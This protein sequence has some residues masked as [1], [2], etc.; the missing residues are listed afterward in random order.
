MCLSWMLVPHRHTSPRT[1][2]RHGGGVAAGADRARRSCQQPPRR[3]T[4]GVGDGVWMT[5]TTPCSPC[6]NLSGRTHASRCPPS[7]TVT[8]WDRQT[9]T[10]AGREA[11]HDGL[12]PRKSGVSPAPFRRRSLPPRS[13]SAQLRPD[14]YRGRD[15]PGLQLSSCNL[16]IFISG[17]WPGSGLVIVGAGLQAAVQDADQAVGQL[18]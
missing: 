14:I 12:S 13:V 3:A 4:P 17:C 7:P 1:S 2:L 15:I 9:V 5:S 6:R 10:I 11:R 8:Q 16:L 18:T